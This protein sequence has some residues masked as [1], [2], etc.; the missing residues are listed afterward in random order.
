MVNH[1]L[2]PSIRRSNVMEICSKMIL[3]VTVIVREI[4]WIPDWPRNNPN[5][6]FLLSQQLQLRA[7]SS[8]SLS[9]NAL[10]DLKHHQRQHQERVSTGGAATATADYS[11]QHH[12]EEDNCA[13]VVE[14]RG[15]G[16]EIYETARSHNAQP[17]QHH[18]EEAGPNNGQGKS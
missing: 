5:R 11:L 4:C 3:M 13:T 8:P 1:P 9:E 7:V 16:S 6:F 10:G 18:G 17:H 15:N 2:L 12:V 14:V